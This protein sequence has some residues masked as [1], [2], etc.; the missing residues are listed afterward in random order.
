MKY[1]LAAYDLGYRSS[2]G[3][4]WVWHHASLSAA[5]L[6][7]AYDAVREAGLPDKPNE[8]PPGFLKGGFGRLDEDWF[9]VHRCYNGGYDGHGRPQRWVLLCAF[10]RADELLRRDPLKLLCCGPF[11]EWAHGPV[12][13]PLPG[14]S[15]LEG[16]LAPEPTTTVSANLAKQLKEAGRLK[17]LTLRDAAMLVASSSA[18]S[19][20]RMAVS[21]PVD[22]ARAVVW[23]R[24]SPHPISK[25][26]LTPKENRPPSSITPNVPA[27]Q[28]SQVSPS[29]FANT[30]DRVLKCVAVSAISFVLGVVAQHFIQFIPETPAR[31]SLPSSEFESPTENRS[32]PPPASEKKDRKPITLQ[33]S[34]N[35]RPMPN[36]DTR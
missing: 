22:L 23:S 27:P 8:W 25:D 26:V 13:L 11:A 6:S 19:I 28:L 36:S 29:V 20:I 14:P 24:R 18:E 2:G 12:P 4:Y 15:V 34:P 35:S 10:L 3:N 30:K 5:T 9:L 32:H 16:E 7:K 21:G 33:H 17:E 1:C 31:K